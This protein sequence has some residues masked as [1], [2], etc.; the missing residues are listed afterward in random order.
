MSLNRRMTLGSVRS[1]FAAAQ[2]FI[3]WWGY[4]KVLRGGNWK[5][6]KN[7]ERDAKSSSILIVCEGNVSCVGFSKL[8]SFQKVIRGNKNDKPMTRRFSTLKINT[9]KRCLLEVRT[10]FRELIWNWQIGGGGGVYVMKRQRK[11]EGRGG[12]GN[13]LN[14]GEPSEE[15][16]CMLLTGVIAKASWLGKRYIVPQPQLRNIILHQQNPYE[17]RGK[18]KKKIEKK[19][20]HIKGKPRYELQESQLVRAALFDTTPGEPERLGEDKWPD[21]YCLHV[22]REA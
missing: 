8:G 7:H 20:I 5:R 4:I 21:Y 6:R 11:K 10:W 14:R 13:H 22:S 18:K 17:Q 9:V 15:L 2:R 19:S 12:G 3:F 16:D 1:D